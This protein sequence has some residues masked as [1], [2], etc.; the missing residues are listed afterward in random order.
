MKMLDKQG[1]VELEEGTTVYGI[2]LV[3]AYNYMIVFYASLCHVDHVRG[4]YYILFR[5]IRHL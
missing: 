2:L 5:D 1:F 3:E 4:Y